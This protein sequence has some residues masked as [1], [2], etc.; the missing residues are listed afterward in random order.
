M[1]P[2]ATCVLPGEQTLT[3]VQCVG[4]LELVGRR[5]HSRKA[6]VRTHGSKAIWKNMIRSPSSRSSSSMI[7]R[8]KVTNNSEALRKFELGRC[9]SR[10]LLWDL[11]GCVHIRILFHFRNRGMD[12]GIEHHYLEQIPFW[13]LNG[14][15]SD[16]NIYVERQY[17]SY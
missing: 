11:S 2:C 10:P 12:S 16:L 1:C 5:I 3:S 14:R 4:C 7:F 9:F 15:Q 8:K 13:N 6:S 17:I